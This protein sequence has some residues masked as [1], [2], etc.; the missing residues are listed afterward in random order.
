MLRALTVLAVLAISSGCATRPP[1]PHPIESPV[2]L[3]P[4]APIERSDR[5]AQLVQLASQQ[6]GA[7]YRYGGATPAGFDCSGLVQFVHAELG[8]ALPRTAAAQFAAAAPRRAA[9]LAPGDLVFFRGERGRI[10]HVGIY[11][12]HGHFVHA[13]REGRPVSV[14]RLDDDGY[15]ARRFAAGGTFI[16]E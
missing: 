11:A 9:E 12:G 6:L 13:P 4:E 7:P 2:E 15:F 16:P 8:L 14:E 3:P 10:D 1:A 5:R